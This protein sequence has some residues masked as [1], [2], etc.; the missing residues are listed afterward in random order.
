MEREAWAEGL[1]LW[2]VFDV[3]KS[4]EFV[5]RSDKNAAKVALQQATEAHQAAT[6]EVAEQ[7]AALSKFLT[8]Q[9]FWSSKT[10]EIAE[11]Q[12]AMERL[13]AYEGDADVEMAEPPAA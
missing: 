8:E 6:E 10:N 5:A 11:A 13:I 4:K 1:G 3:A 9:T 12:A 2:A 7:E